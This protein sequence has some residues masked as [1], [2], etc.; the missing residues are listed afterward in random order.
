MDYLM[1]SKVKCNIILLAVKQLINA[2]AN[3]KNHMSRTVQ[4][5]I[6]KVLTLLEG[7]NYNITLYYD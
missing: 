3:V 1:Q 6:C 5:V 4:L 2:I 7:K